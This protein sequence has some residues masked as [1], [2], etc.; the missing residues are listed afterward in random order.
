MRKL[1][2]LRRRRLLNELAAVCALSGW[3]GSAEAQTYSNAPTAFSWIDPSTHTPVTWS[4]PTV[5]AGFADTIGD[6]ALTNQLDIGFTFQFGAVNYTQL[7]I[8]TNGRLQ[9]G[10]TSCGAGTQVV[11]PPRT[12]TLPYADASLVNTMKIY[13]ADIDASPNGSGAARAPRHARRRPAPCVTPRRL[14]ARRRTASS[15]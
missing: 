14:W 8:M 9:F 6:D 15:S 13:G 11:G 12:Y 5:C 10:N 1:A 3:A 2:F 7:Y 4:N